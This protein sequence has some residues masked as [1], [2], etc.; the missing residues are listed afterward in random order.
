MP[1][2]HG[3]G[4]VKLVLLLVYLIWYCGMLFPFL[5]R[6]SLSAKSNFSLPDFPSLILSIL[7][8][9]SRAFSISY[10]L[11]HDFRFEFICPGLLHLALK[12]MLGSAEGKP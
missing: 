9:F 11:W 8:F 7:G 12:E 6:E 2:V 4:Y 5:S 1:I 3:M 10:G